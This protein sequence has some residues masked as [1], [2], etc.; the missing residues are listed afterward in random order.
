MRDRSRLDRV[1]GGMVLGANDTL[2]TISLHIAELTAAEL[3][4]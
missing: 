3:D 2:A 4:R 1:I